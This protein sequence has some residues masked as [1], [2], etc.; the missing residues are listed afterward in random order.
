LNQI[1]FENSNHFHTKALGTSTY[2]SPEQLN[3]EQYDHKSDMFSLGIILFEFFALFSTNFERTCA[4]KDLRK[5]LLHEPFQKRY[6]QESIHIL[7]L[8]SN[9]P[10]KRPSAAELLKSF[11]LLEE[12]NEIQHLRQ[13]IKLKDMLIQEQRDQIQ[14]LQRLLLEA[15][16]RK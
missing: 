3:G 5:R 1:F 16:D 4:L 2:A 7:A 10:K 12:E 8:L 15:R 6:P 14:Q 11:T 13:E 9:D